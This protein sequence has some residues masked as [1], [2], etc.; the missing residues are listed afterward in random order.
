MVDFLEICDIFRTHN[1]LVQIVLLVSSASSPQSSRIAIIIICSLS[2]IYMCVFSHDIAFTTRIDIIAFISVCDGLLYFFYRYLFNEDYQLLCRQIEH[3]HFSRTMLIVG[4]EVWYNRDVNSYIHTYM[5]VTCIYVY[6]YIDKIY[7]L[8]HKS[9]NLLY[10][11]ILNS[12]LSGFGYS[13][14]HIT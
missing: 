6:T 1:Q 11:H 2:H 14:I 13:I 10:F 8:P 4:H 3:L 7:I 5:F 9:F 12:F